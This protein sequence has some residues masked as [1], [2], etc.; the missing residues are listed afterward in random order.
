MDSPP[1][2]RVRSVLS[3]IVHTLTRK[4]SFHGSDRRALAT[5]L[6][7]FVVVLVLLVAVFFVFLSQERLPPPARLSFT[8]PVVT[9]WGADFNVTFNVSAVLGGPYP[10]SGFLVNLTVQTF[11]GQAPLGFNGRPFGIRIGP[12]LYEV[13]WMDRDLDG[14]VS[15]GDAFEVTGLPALSACAFTLVFPA[16]PWAASA[17]WTTSSE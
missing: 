2:P 16:G 9:P 1:R 6:G 7:V 5:L 3:E 4:P 15:A 11:S 14:N 12:G 8:A 10:A 17:Y 13:T